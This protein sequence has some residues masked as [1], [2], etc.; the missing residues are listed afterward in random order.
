MLFP[1]SLI[2]LLA[3]PLALAAPI[4]ERDPAP[5]SASSTQLSS[6]IEPARLAAAAYCPLT[7]GRVVGTQAKVLWATGDGR[8]VQ[9]V[10]VAYSPSQGI[11][12]AHQVS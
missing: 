3:L 10:Y 5:V 8:N 6:Y 12:V 9:R 7:A 4:A 11:V 2:A 1:R